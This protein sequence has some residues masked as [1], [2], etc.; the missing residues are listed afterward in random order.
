[1]TRVI[2]KPEVRRQEIMCAAQKLFERHGY[3]NTSVEA[4]IE[5]AAISKG[6][7]Y[8]YFAAKKEV[9]IALVEQLASDMEAHFTAIVSMENLTAIEKLKLLLRGKEK[10]TLVEQPV[11]AMIHKPDNRE[12]RERLNVFAIKTLAPLLAKVLEQ[13]NDEGVFQAKTPL[14]TTQLM[15]ATSQ[16]MV[17]SDLFEWTPEEKMKLLKTLQTTFEIAIHAKPGSLDFIASC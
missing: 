7:F 5:E 15:L 12:L 4:I 9:L 6:A 11:V 16:F 1:M 17:D 3:E 2:K 8:H 14:E 10:T 13:G